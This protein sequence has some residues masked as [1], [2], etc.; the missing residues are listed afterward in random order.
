MAL[1]TGAFGKLGP[2]WCKALLEA[3]A[4]VAVCDHPDANESP[5]ICEL[6]NQYGTARIKLFRGDVLDRDSQHELRKRVVRDLGPLDVLVNNAGIDNPPK[7]RES[8]RIED[9]PKEDFLSVVN[10]NLYGVFLV[11]QIFGSDMV[12][13]G[14]GSIINIGSLYGS[15]SPD[16]SFYT[17]IDSDPPFIKP[18]AYAA[19][20]AGLLQLTRYFAAHW[21]ESGVRVNA[22]SPGGVED[23]QDEDFK[24]KFCTRV[25]LKRMA[26]AKDLIGPLV[27]LA[28]DAS[29]Y[30][31][32]QNLQVDGGFTI[33]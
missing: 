22:L 4:V 33:W 28:S 19:S 9:I 12:K 8:L 10:V 15:V 21:G 7:L 27:F 24:A 25:P 18:P 13:M 26:L 31:T 32:G 30:V 6:L 29:L 3:G 20:K 1:L 11:S 16:S 2:V 5:E 14:K 23:D 17:H